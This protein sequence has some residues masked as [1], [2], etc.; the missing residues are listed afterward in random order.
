[1]EDNYN[2]KAES[3]PFKLPEVITIEEF[4]NILIH[5]KRPHH[6]LAFKLAFL[7]GMRVREVINLMPEDIDKGRRLIFIR[8]SK[9]KKDRYVPLAKPLERDLK[10]LPVKCGVRA[11]EM[12]IKNIAKKSINKNIHFHTLRHSSATFY[13][14]QGMSLPELQLFLGHARINTTMIYLHVNPQDLIKKFDSIWK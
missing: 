1:M 6:K 11:L 13:L 9:G 12:A 3:K 2:I 8:Q 14:S 10:A 7:C 4:N 5:T